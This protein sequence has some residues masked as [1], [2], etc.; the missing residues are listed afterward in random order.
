VLARAPDDIREVI[1]ELLGISEQL[2]DRPVPAA[3]LSSETMTE[4]QYNS[5]R[6]RNTTFV[7]LAALPPGAVKPV[8]TAVRTPLEFVAITDS[9]H[10]S[11]LALSDQANYLF[12]SKDGVG[13][14][15]TFYTG[16]SGEKRR[17]RTL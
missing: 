7:S 14:Q 4:E 5:L 9:Q 2:P 11:L 3:F 12:L 13:Y 6:Q 17:A 15:I 10:D 1:K 8:A 16:T